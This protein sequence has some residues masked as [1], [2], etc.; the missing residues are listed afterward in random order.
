MKD[1][2][3]LTIIIG[4]LFGA[5]IGK[6]PLSAPDGARYSEI[7][8]EMLVTG[9][10]ITP[11]LDGIKYFEKPPLFYW[12]QAV[13]LKVFGI[14]EFAAN[15]ANTLM[16]LLTCLL[17]YLSGRKLFS[18]QT[19]FIASLILASSILFYAMSQLITLDM[20]LTFFLSACL[21]S[22]IAATKE[23]FGIK[24]DCLLWSMYIFAG[25]AVMTKGLI[26][27]IFPI[28]IIFF[29]LLLFNEWRNLKTYKIFS[30]S[31]LFLI[32]TLPWHIL[33][34]VKNPEFF[35]FYFIEQ[36]FLRFFTH[37]AGRGQPWW[38]FIAVLFIG[39]F[40][41]I[42]FL[43]Q[44]ILYNF[45]KKFLKFPEYKQTIFF[46]IWI[47]LIFVF[48]SISSSKLI[49]YILP[50]MPPLAI[51]TGNYL[52]NIFYT[53]KMRSF[54]I[55][56]FCIILFELIFSIAITISIL[57]QI[58]FIKPIN[59]INL[60]ITAGLLLL[61]IIATFF[62]YKKYSIKQ[63][64]VTLLI[65]FSFVLVSLTPILPTANGESTK[66]LALTIKAKADPNDE[67]ASYKDYYQDLPFYLEHRVTVVDFTGELDFGSKHQDAKD[68]MIDE[69]T[70]WNR[71]QSNKK[72]FMVLNKKMY[73][74]LNNKMPNK[75]FLIAEGFDD[76]A[77]SNY[78]E[79][80]I[81]KN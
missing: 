38:F 40:P 33:V 43:P 52:A 12:M 18:R 19:G 36:H 78:N 81:M 77:V 57:F 68:W 54:S 79:K 5:I 22:F 70:F 15:F 62:Y 51:L 58:D 50:I 71:W 61:S 6:Y 75:L 10:F 27:I 74:E 35:H 46:L 25:L 65:S 8:R 29:Y 44:T 66:N 9:D 16:A 67:V 73:H 48:Y 76:V 28:G 30:G 49:P 4:I 1:F 80:L 64:L 23:P 42:F 26:G 34:Q 72:M 11:H 2:C 7:P 37:Y 63:T 45:P 32:I 24:R 41:W 60:L 13:S 17:V 53:A 31:I 69:K 3:I 20:T 47:I 14:N 55:S 21:F 59:K 39:F 56:I